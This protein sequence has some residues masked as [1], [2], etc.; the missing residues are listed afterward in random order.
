MVRHEILVLICVGSSP[1]TLV[2]NKGVIIMKCKCKG[3]TDRYVGCHS[4]C[5]DYKAYTAIME[6]RR[7][8]KQ[9]QAKIN[10]DV[11][12]VRKAMKRER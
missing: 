4:E 11:V 9:R 3:C 1:T 7:V 5:E 12:G 10:A 2:S 6:D 8:E